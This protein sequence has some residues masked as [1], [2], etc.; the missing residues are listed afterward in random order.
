MSA[1]RGKLVNPHSYKVVSTI[2]DPIVEY[3]DYL[4]QPFSSQKTISELL[5]SFA[6][7]W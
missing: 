4:A 7:P 2:V 6:S 3:L 1:A 5:M